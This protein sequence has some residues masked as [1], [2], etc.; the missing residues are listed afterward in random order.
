MRL[1]SAFL[2]FLLFSSFA[3]ARPLTIAV[4]SNFRAPAEAIVRAYTEESG[5]LARISS[6]STS[7]LYAQI[8]NGAPFD[9]FLAADSKHPRLL[10]EAALTI[11][12]S[13]STYAVG[14]LV[15]WSRKE[16][17]CRQALEGLGKRHLAIANPQT[18]PYGIA[19]RQFLV[20]AGLW[21]RVEPRLVYGENVAQAMQFV[22]TRNAQ[23]GLIAA[24]QAADPNSPP[25]SCA[26]AVPAGMHEPIEQQLVVLRRT[27]MNPAISAFVEF[28]A[29]D[30]AKNIIQEFG[31]RIPE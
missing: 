30:A 6:A 7:K 3:D 12:G 21:E 14:G 18:A 29:G 9:I 19:A 24:S 5:N 22:A 20:S 16:T 17:D 27:E 2:V 25:S 26:W 8:R 15:L 31:Y 1:G 28:L 23:L 10:E 11:E 4:A 13:R